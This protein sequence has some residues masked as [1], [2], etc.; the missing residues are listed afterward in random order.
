M[1]RLRAGRASLLVAAVVA[2]LGAAFFRTQIFRNDDYLLR[3]DENRMRVIPLPAPRGSM[4]DRNGELIAGTTV[5]HALYLQPVAPDADRDGLLL[6]QPGL[7]FEDAELDGMLAR[8]GEEPETPLLISP[9]LS[10]EQL[11]WLEENRTELPDFLLEEEPRRQF[12]I[13]E[14]VAHLVGH[15]AEISADELADT[16]GWRGY[17]RG[18][19][20][21][22]GG[23]EREYEGV[24]GGTPGERYVEVD[25]YGRIV[26][27][28]APREMRQPLPGRSIQLSIDL[29][30]QR[31]IHE[32]FPKEYDGAVVALEPG[33]GEVLA[34]Y[35]HPTYDPN[36][37]NG[38]ADRA[39]WAE[40]NSNPRRPLLNRALAG[41][42]APGSTWKL[43]TAII[44]LETEVIDEDTRMPQGCSGGMNYAGRYWG[45]WN[46]NGHGSV[47][48]AGA[49]GTSCNVYFYQ[50]GIW[51]GLNQ[52]A[53]EG[54]RLGFSR[55][56]GVDLPGER[57]GVFPSDS[58]WYRNWFGRA[59]SSGE[60]M[61]LSIGQGPNSQTPLR[62]AQFFSALAGNGRA[63]SP[64]IVADGTRRTLET[65]LGIHPETLAIVREGLA[66]VL[67]PGGTAYMSSLRRWT[68]Y[69]KTGT[70]QNPEDRG[71]PHAWFA[72]F[73]GVPDGP[74]EIAFSVVVEFG[75]S[76]SG[77]AAPIGAKLADFY[78]N[79]KYGYETERLQT[80][81]ERTT[82]R[83]VGE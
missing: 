72:G 11:A 45:C 19:M 27:T 29:E 46:R 35:S 36:E 24:L 55:R 57:A 15:V 62:M 26:G 28:I 79:R 83:A 61:N 20:V 25:A 58:E 43:A 10:F 76:G 81:G 31:F 2:I 59:A 49:I 34:L 54:T 40:L 70:S 39:L 17:R 1:R 64:R 3:A 23:L 48:L 22:K 71:R 60:V 32:I 37:L 42:Y 47:D 73:A 53:K 5:S 68:L 21:G 78:L 63:T 51:L 74:P 6:L 9:S 16:I 30:L 82:G 41:I 33:T 80:L 65:D 77:V 7:G 12:P 52:L 66:R 75:E 69:G 18:Q 56:T 4:V 8:L 44:G 50:L 13:G 67:E 14:A 38:G